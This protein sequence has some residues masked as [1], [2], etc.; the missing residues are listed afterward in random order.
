MFYRF[1]FLAEASD[2][3]KLMREAADLV[4]WIN[5][6]ERIA[7][8]ESLGKGPDDVEE[9]QRRF[10]EFQKELRTNELRLVRLN[11]IAE[12][13]LQLGRTDAALKIQMD[14]NNLNRKWDDLKKNAEEREQQLLSAYEV[15]RFTRDAEEAQD[16]ISEKFEQLDPNELGQDLRSVKRLQKKHE[17]Y[18]RDLNALGDKIRELDDLTKRLINTHPEQAEVIIQKQ[19]VIQNQWTDLTSKAD[20]HKAKLLDDYDYQKFLTDFRDLAAVIKS[21]IQQI[22]SDELARDVPGAEALL[23]RHHEH[24]SEIDARSGAFQAFEDFGNDLINAEH[25][26]EEDI[27]QKLQEMD[28][29]R[30]QLEA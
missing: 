8:E 5:D 16:W 21:I 12:K 26:A 17:A 10:D 3:Y 27:K 2:A 11:S 23:E 24:R 30:Q 18:E 4:V 20:L 6:K 14:I 13:L 28:D 29:I 7:S 22:S 19:Q 25:F 9:L 15:Q 1:F